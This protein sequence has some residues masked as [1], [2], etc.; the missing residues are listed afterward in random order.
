[1]EEE[2]PSMPIRKHFEQLRYRLL[3]SVGGFFVLFLLCFPIQS[4]LMEFIISPLH[5]VYDKDLTVLDPSEAILQYLKVNVIFALVFSSPWIG[6]Q[7]WKFVGKGLY[8]EERNVIYKYTAATVLLFLCGVAFS[9]FLLMPLII[10]FLVQFDPAQVAEIQLQFSR[11]IHFFFKITLIIGSVFMLPVFMKFLQRMGVIQK[12]AW[13]SG[14][15]YFLILA[16]LLAA[17]VS[18]PDPISQIAIAL[19]FLL[20]YEAGLLFMY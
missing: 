3:L 7:I 13:K 4:Q 17:L 15:K 5:T 18:P 10:R 2:S 9:Y 11:Y 1:M 12:E 19:P 20:L 14:R 16:F 6:L 8:S